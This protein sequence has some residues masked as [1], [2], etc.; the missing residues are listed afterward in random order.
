M[1]KIET[2]DKFWAQ[3]AQVTEGFL[4][5]ML[6]DEIIWKRWPLEGEDLKDIR[7][8]EGKIL[9][10]RIFDDQRELHMARGDVGR[11]MQGRIADD[12]AGNLEEQDYFDEEQYLDIDTKRSGEHF[13]QEGKVRATGG[14]WYELP[15]SGMEDAKVRIRNYL[16]YYE[17]SGQAYVKDWRMAGIFQEKR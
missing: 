16:G 5:A 11:R 9:D 1:D 10:I 17:D 15:L 12:T 3:A 8:K 4:L 13:R 7:Q 14:G 6:T 2:M